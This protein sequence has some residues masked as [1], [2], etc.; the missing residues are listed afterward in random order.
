MNKFKMN[1]GVVSL[2]VL[3]ASLFGC[4]KQSA[5]DNNA[6]TESPSEIVAA[7]A[8]GSSNAG[9]N[10]GMNAV[11]PAART[12]FL[13]EAR[14]FL[15]PFPDARAAAS[16]PYYAVGSTV[17]A[18]N[19][20]TFTYNDC[21]FG[22]SIATWTGSQTLQFGGAATCNTTVL[23]LT[24]AGAGTLTRTIAP[25]TV[26]ISPFGLSVILDTQNASGYYQSVSG[27][28]LI[29]GVAGG[30]TVTIDGIH[31]VSSNW[32]HSL[33][34]TS[35]LQVTIDGSGNRTFTSGTIQIQHNLAKF[36]GSAVLNNMYVAAGTC[37]PSSG[38]ITTTF[39]G[40]RTGSE[41]LVFNGGTKATLTSSSGQV[42]NVTLSHCF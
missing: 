30:H 9:Q 4:G 42:T 3:A 21:S 6:S 8:A 15:T 33:S 18:G 40:N 31:L 29:T 34:T 20:V 41:T 27:G 35:P 22:S 14:D 28:F 25:N 39:S 1:I 36:V 10:V 24:G 32:N 23:P 12:T 13:A 37:F 2:I 5:T 11:D 26:R 7:T 19:A 17:C 16:C 38:S